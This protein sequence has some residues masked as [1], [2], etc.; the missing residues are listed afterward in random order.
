[1]SVMLYFIFLLVFLFLRAGVDFNCINAYGV[2]YVDCCIYFESTF[3]RSTFGLYSVVPG[4]TTLMPHSPRGGTVWL[5]WVNHVDTLEYFFF[6]Q[7]FLPKCVFPPVHHW[8]SYLWSSLLSCNGLTS[9]DLSKAVFV[10]SLFFW[11]SCDGVISSREDA[12]RQRMTLK[13]AAILLLSVWQFEL[14]EVELHGG[15]ALV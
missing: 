2:I 4:V 9:S 10:W 12:T 14:F 11:K 15:L 6:L 7:C 5:E 13:I 1:M 8:V 3:S